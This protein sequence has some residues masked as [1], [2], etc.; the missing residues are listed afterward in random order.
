M[1]TKLFSRLT[2]A[3]KYFS[4]SMYKDIV[5]RAFK[6]FEDGEED[7][8][9]TLLNKLPSRAKLISKLVEKLKDK[10]VYKTLKKISE[11]KVEDNLEMIKG[12]HSLGTHV[13]IEMKKGSKEYGILLP[14]I[15]EKIGEA[16]LQSGK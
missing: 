1:D 2:E 6:Y 4:D 13:C 11:D 9:K 10:P 14:L 5:E 8:A 15:H 7:K 16:L 3:E 12:L